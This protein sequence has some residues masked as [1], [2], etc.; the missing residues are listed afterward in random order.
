M[1][2]QKS[3]ALDIG[4]L[5]S[6]NGLSDIGI[7]N[8]CVAFECNN[9]Q[10]VDNSKTISNNTN[11]NIVSESDNTNISTGENSNKPNGPTCVVCFENANLTLD[12][13][14]LLLALG[15]VSSI[16]EF[17]PTL[18]DVSVEEFTE[19]LTFAGVDNEQQAQSLVDCLVEAGLLQ[20]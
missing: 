3:N 6:F 20:G 19:A 13:E 7:S 2:Y 16:E 10:T 1:P 12:Q 15:K 9:Q 5:G 11:S 17:C 14:Q 4:E 18:V 8:N